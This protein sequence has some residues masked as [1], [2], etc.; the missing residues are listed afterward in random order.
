MAWQ[1]VHAYQT[2]SDHP[3]IVALNVLHQKTVQI[4]LRVS[5]KNAKT[6]ALVYVDVELCVKFLNIMQFALARKDIQETVLKVVNPFAF[7][8]RVRNSLISLPEYFY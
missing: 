7:K 4:T 1:F 8:P 3:H 5:I 2:I 6:L